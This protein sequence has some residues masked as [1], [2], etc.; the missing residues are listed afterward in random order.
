ME[1]V[2]PERTTD[3][4]RRGVIGFALEAVAARAGVAKT[5]GTARGISQGTCK[6]MCACAAQITTRRNFHPPAAT[7]IER[8]EG[9][10]WQH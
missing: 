2:R 4:A 8:D 5:T 1:Q 10:R 3:G 9:G 7:P 6:S